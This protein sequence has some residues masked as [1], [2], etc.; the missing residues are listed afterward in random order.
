[1]FIIMHLRPEVPILRT[2]QRSRGEMRVEGYRM[3]T[4]RKSVEIVDRCEHAILQ[5]AAK[6]MVLPR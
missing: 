3:L 5:I 4:W 1:M 6:S 2:Q